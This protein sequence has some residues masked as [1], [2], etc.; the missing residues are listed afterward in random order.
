MHRCE[1]APRSGSDVPPNHRGD[2]PGSR[3]RQGQGA[4]DERDLVGALKIM[5][6]QGALDRTL[7]EWAQEVRGLGNVGG[8]FDPYENVDREQA[9]ELSQLVR[10]LLRYLY[11]EPDRMARLRASRK[12]PE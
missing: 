8:H 10:A 7:G 2:R 1:R 4:V 5:A 3:Q 6:N 12:Q 11:E 9:G